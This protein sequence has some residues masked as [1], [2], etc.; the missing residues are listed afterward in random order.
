MSPRIVLAARG[1]HACEGQIIVDRRA[2][3]PGA[4]REDGPAR[5]SALRAIAVHAGLLMR[6]GIGEHATPSKAVELV[7]RHIKASVA[8]AER[9]RNAL[10]DEGIE[11]LSRGAPN[12]DAL[13]QRAHIIEPA[14]ARLIHKRQRGED[15]HPFIGRMRGH[16]GRFS[17]GQAQIAS[18]FDNR[19]THIE[20]V[21]NPATLTKVAESDVDRTSGAEP[22]V[23]SV[24][25]MSGWTLEAA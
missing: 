9:T 22:R 7:G 14:F 21:A 25:A 23:P 19:Q 3:S 4:R 1:Q 15:A 13:D 12:Q 11:I 8:H 5:V 20:K 18:G 17:Q 2:K 10:L 24:R 16:R 6:G